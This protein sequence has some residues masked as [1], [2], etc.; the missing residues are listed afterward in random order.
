MN[1]KG[2]GGD[3]VDGRQGEGV[4]VGGEG[5]ESDR[6]ESSRNNNDVSV[7]N[8]NRK[9]SKKNRPSSPAKSDRSKSRSTQSLDAHTDSEDF[10]YPPQ[11]ETL[12]D[13]HHH[14]QHQHQNHHSQQHHQAAQLGLIQTTKLK[15]SQN[16]WVWRI[17]K[18]AV[19][20]QLALVLV[21]CAACFFEPHCCDAL[22]TY[23]MSFTPQ[24]RYIKGP[25]P[26]S[27]VVQNR[28][29]TGLAGGRARV[30]E[31]EKCESFLEVSVLIK[32]IRN[33]GKVPCLREAPH[34]GG[35]FLLLLFVVTSSSIILKW[36]F[37]RAIP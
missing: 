4:G 32:T 29:E 25:P 23:S 34:E 33:K 31:E 5:A 2:L 19:P 11:V 20:V 35:S 13:P 30:K 26:V 27:W 16:R 10:P 24:L 22:N 7:K 9:G 1:E 36:N 17:T 18:I 3:G 28:L 8:K 14:H 21:M 37:N 12:A 6:G 15:L